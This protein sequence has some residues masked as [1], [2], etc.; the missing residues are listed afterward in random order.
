[1]SINQSMIDQFKIFEQS[2]AEQVSAM[3]KTLGLGEIA[4]A[5]V[6]A[7]TKKAKKSAKAEE[8]SVQAEPKEPKAPNAWMTL[9][10]DTVTDMKANGWTEWTDVDGNLWNGSRPQTATD[11]KGQKVSDHVYDGGAN[12]GKP[13]SHALGGMKR[14]SF[15]KGQSDPA[16]TA[17]SKAYRDGLAEKRS[18]SSVGSAEKEAPVADEPKKKAGRPRKPKAAEALTEPAAAT[19]EFTEV[20]ASTPAAT[21][22]K[23]K[24]VVMAPKK[25]KKVDLSF[26]PWEH[27]GKTYITN[28]RG[29]VIEPEEGVWVGRF[30]GTT[31]DESIEEPSDLDGVTMRE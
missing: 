13:P 24:K 27:A 5:P 6:S 28:D 29:D 1:M 22:A 26:F 17:K 7:K 15:L 12:D 18:A 23:A 31:I 19:E 30:N 14:A 25:A 9:I 10:A 3:R 4:P 11:A 2:M 8:G 20:E 21:P 16:H